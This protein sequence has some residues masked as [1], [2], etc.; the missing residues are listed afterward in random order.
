[1][2]YCLGITGVD[3]IAENLMFERFLNAE[4]DTISFSVRIDVEKGSKKL[5]VDYASDKYGNGM[6]MLLEMMDILIKEWVELSII[7]DT[8]KNIS[9]SK[10]KKI[11]LA[12]IDKNDPTVFELLLSSDIEGI[13]C[14][15]KDTALYEAISPKNM[16]DLMAAITLDRPLPEEYVGKYLCNIKNPQY[17][18]YECSELAPILSTTYGCVIYQEQVM[19]I[20]Q[21]IGGFS[22]EK[23][24]L[25]RRDLSKRKSSTIGN[26]RE[27]F[28][29]GAISSKTIGADTANTIFDELWDEARYCFNKSHVAAFSLM[30]YEMAW[31]KAYFRLEF[32][33]AVEKYRGMK[34]DI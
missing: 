22:T 20:L 24:D 28:V 29:Y 7:K 8:I 17:I 6:P 4:C 15:D 27:D 18:N 10:G 30:I 13:S 34:S 2:A 11:D 19:R 26:M 23:S 5:L 12:G 33:E 16:D 9:S 14:F 32:M 31:L 25:C 1:M 3:P 21:D